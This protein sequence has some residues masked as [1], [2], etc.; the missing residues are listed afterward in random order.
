METEEGLQTDMRAQLTEM[1]VR[2]RRNGTAVDGCTFVCVCT[3]D[4]CACSMLFAVPA[5][6]NM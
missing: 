2:G 4:Y 5:A 3:C 1:R 6:V